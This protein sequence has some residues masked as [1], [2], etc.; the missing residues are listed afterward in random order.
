MKTHIH[1]LSGLHRRLNI[2]KSTGAGLPQLGKVSGPHPDVFVVYQPLSTG[3]YTTLLT[4]G[5]S[6]V[7]PQLLFLIR[8]SPFLFTDYSETLQLVSALLFMHTHRCQK[9]KS[10][11]RTLNLE[12]ESFR[13]AICS[14]LLLLQ[15]SKARFLVSCLRS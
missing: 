1:N 2:L 13:E 3:L 6:L 5:G 9:E 4:S 11:S 15:M 8:L 7:Q 12:R 14:N 10:S